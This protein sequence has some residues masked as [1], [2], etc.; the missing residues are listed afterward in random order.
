MDAHTKRMHY[1]IGYWKNE[2]NCEQAGFNL[3]FNKIKQLNEEIQD[4]DEQISSSGVGGGNGVGDNSNSSGRNIVSESAREIAFAR[5]RAA[6]KELDEYV[7]NGVIID[8]IHIANIDVPFQT[9][10]DEGNDEWAL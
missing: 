1:L 9:M 6:Q 3:N 5:R 7:A 10:V 2:K 8:M 4:I